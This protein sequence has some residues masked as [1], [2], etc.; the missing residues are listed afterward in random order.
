[1]GG[2]NFT[3]F[4]LGGHAQARRVWRTYFPAVNAVVFIVD[5]HDRERIQESKAELD[6]RLSTSPFFERNKGSKEEQKS[7]LFTYATKFLLFPTH[8][9]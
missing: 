2:I 8:R 3:T 5:S 4:D 9:A 6:V 1:M 7:S